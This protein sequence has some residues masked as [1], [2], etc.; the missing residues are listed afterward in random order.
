MK[1]LLQITAFYLFLLPVGMIS[2]YGQS[3]VSLTNRDKNV[4]NSRNENTT[5]TALKS[6]VVSKLSSV[7]LTSLF[8]DTRAEIRVAFNAGNSVFN[9]GVAQSFSQKPKVVNLLD[10]DGLTTGSTFSVAWQ[11]RIGSIKIPDRLPIVDLGLFNKIKDE[12]RAKKGIPEAE[13][14]SFNMFDTEFRNKVINSGAID[15]RAFETPLFFTAQ[16]SAS[17]VGFDYIADLTATQPLSSQEINK[18]FTFSLSKFTSLDVYYSLSYSVLYT[19]QSGGEVISYSFPAGNNGL[20][21][22]KD[23]T[24]GTPAEKIDSR[25]KGEVRQ[26]FRGDDFTPILGINP[27][28][29]VLLKSERINVDVPVYFL[30]KNSD[31]VFNGLQAGFKVGYT[32][33]W[34]D[35]FFRDLGSF[36]TNKMY[37]S[38]FLAKPFSVG[39]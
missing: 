30:T 39:N 5:N 28:V 24:V 21:Y 26:L 14:V 25:L 11:K 16:F 35:S 3:T 37:F 10:A 13:G 38:L 4:I 32:S 7:N 12:F 18:N 8:N 31:G 36:S 29:S 27:S 19:Y 34:D 1:K 23:V 20:S 2:L 33:K 15:L 17:R 6:G 9:V 22:S